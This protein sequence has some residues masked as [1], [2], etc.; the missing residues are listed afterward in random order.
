MDQTTLLTRV[1][2]M[3]YRYDEVSR[4]MNALEKAVGEYEG[5]RSEIEIL[6]EYVD[7]GLWIKDFEADEAGAIPATIKRGVLSED[8][9]YDLLQ[10]MDRIIE[11]SREVFNEKNSEK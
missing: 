11:H 7:S 9:L 4:V 8:G 3:E 1:I 10:D 2:S 5:I 6:K